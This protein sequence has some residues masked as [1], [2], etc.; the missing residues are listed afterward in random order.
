MKK[1]FKSIFMKIGFF[2]FVLS[3]FNVSKDKD[4]FNDSQLRKTWV[5]NYSVLFNQ[6]WS[7]KISK[8]FPD[9]ELWL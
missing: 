1:N 8:K 6:G 9:E 3:S 2:V 5:N 7:G 4:K